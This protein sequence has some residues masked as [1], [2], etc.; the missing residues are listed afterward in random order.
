MIGKNVSHYRIIE[1]LGEGGMGE[2]YLAEDTNLKRQ[3]ALKFLPTH[4]SENEEALARFRAEAQAAAALNHPNIITIHEVGSHEGRTYIAMAHVDGHPLS[5]EIQEEISIDRAI[6]LAIQV[7][8]GLDQAHKAGIVHRDIKPDN[9]LVDSDGRLKILDF[10]VAKHEGLGSL[11]QTDSTVGT[12]FYMSPEQT[13][14]DVVDQRTDIFSLGAILY[15]MV[16]GQRPFKGDHV[17]AVQYSI[18]NEEPQ[19]LARYSNK[20]TPELERIVAKALAKDPAARYQSAAD[21][22]V[23]LKQLR[24]VTGTIA[25]T[26][27]SPRRSLGRILIPTSIVFAAILA[28]L[29]FKPFSVEIK[30]DQAAV[31][32]D[33]NT[34][35]IMYFDNMAEESDPRRLG[36]IVTDLLITNLSQSQDMQVV[37]S[38]RLYDLMKLQ[39][40]EGKRVIDRSSATEVAVQAGA[41]WMMM[42]SILQVEPTI[43][44]SS[45]LIDV[46][47]G[48]I[49]AS[50]RITGAPSE[51]VFDIV[52]R[53]TGTTKE[54]LNVPVQ[55]DLEQAA[56]VRDVT[57]G[58]LDAYRAYLDGEESLRKFYRP[59]ARTCY[60][61]AIAHDST[62]AMAWFRLSNVAS[63]G[64]EALRS[65]KQAVKYAEKASKKEQMYIRA[66]EAST[67]F[68]FEQAVT[69]MENIIENYPDEKDAYTILANHYRERMQF[70]KAL[71]HFEKVIEIDPINKL[72][73]NSVAYT[74]RD[75]GNFDESIV[76]INKYIELAPGEANPYDSR[77]DLYAFNGDVDNAIDSYA[78][79]VEIKP[80]FYPSV[81][82][83]GN[84]RM[85][86]NDY[87]RAEQQY[88]TL[89]SDASIGQR[90][91]ARNYLAAIPLRQ[92][93]L[94]E[95]IEMLNAGISADR[96]D[97]LVDWSYATKLMALGEVYQ[98][99]DEPEKSIEHYQLAI[100]I[101]HELFPDE[102]GIARLWSAI[103]QAKNDHV[104]EAEDIVAYFDP[105]ADSLVIAVRG[106]YYA[107][108]GL[109]AEKKEDFATAIEHYE[110][111]FENE[112]GFGIRYALAKAYLKNKQPKEACE[113]LAPALARYDNHVVEAPIIAVR[114]HYVLGCAY[115][116][117]GKSDE[118][119]EQFKT[120]LTLWQHADADFDFDA[121]ADAKS[122]LE[123]LGQS[124]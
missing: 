1:K 96:V 30:P 36:E 93:K 28:L 45:Q 119:A 70:G 43:V 116:E 100:S 88:R 40:H 56:S 122:R 117:A 72:A 20:A 31:A 55:A 79:A 84:M 6:D 32:G 101:F 26:G 41:K 17:A 104:K 65:L 92:G 25:A 71:K 78:K 61:R 81:Q 34:L 83:L 46:N 54:E 16:A 115:Q 10:G 12:A 76:A 18:A 114:G 38:Q 11:T 68:A 107:A 3:V 4:A 66:A 47:T 24:S 52:D 42:G 89:I 82:K 14:G 64:E 51:T 77:A 105:Q 118:A 27:A 111:V 22:A 59:E 73:F 35:A 99:M 103:A 113:T 62:F 58:S 50:Q 48:N 98:W 9:L 63:H 121:I 90:S 75:L 5:T 67:N 39:G 13:R 53:M 37:S 124:I 57:T 102:P 29:V 69:I 21:V 86:K 108:K 112:K 110:T 94:I 123:A 60:Q 95:G 97:A 80:D 23:D 85:Y 120:F 49:A 33:N 8:D 7:C 2:V 74:H 91:W 15:E 87:A 109:I 44:I 106:L 19:P